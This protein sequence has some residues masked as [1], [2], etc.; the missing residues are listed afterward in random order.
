MRL[1]AATFVYVIAVLA[2]AMLWYFF[3]PRQVPPGQPPLAILG[4]SSLEALRADFNRD[5]D[6]TR[7]ILLLSPT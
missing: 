3:G 7:V 2:G 4:A 6:R 1:R 5:A